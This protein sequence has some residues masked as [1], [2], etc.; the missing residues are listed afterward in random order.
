MFESW[1]IAFDKPTSTH[2]V[3]FQ[4]SFTKSP[5]KAISTTCKNI[6]MVNSKKPEAGQKTGNL[7]IN[8]CRILVSTF[9]TRKFIVSTDFQTNKLFQFKIL[10]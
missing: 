8:G 6:T 1:W 7:R 10:G 3:D 9:A 2:F 5:E 4:L